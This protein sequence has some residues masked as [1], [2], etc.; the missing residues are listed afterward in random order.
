M[1][2]A[3]ADFIFGDLLYIILT[4][5]ASYMKGRGFDTIHIDKKLCDR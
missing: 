4:N 5:R 1:A 3:A 2:V